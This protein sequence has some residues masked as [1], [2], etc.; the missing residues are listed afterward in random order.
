MSTKTLVA[1]IALPYAEALLEIVQKCKILE[2]TNQDLIMINQVLLES[3]QLNIFFANPLVKSSSKK[4]VIKQL[5]SGQVSDI[6]LSFL[7]VLT[8]RRRIALLKDIILKYLELE[9]VIQSI[10]IAE[11]RTA[12]QLTDQ[13]KHEL[14]KKLE[15]MTNSMKVDLNITIDTELIAGFKVTIGSKVIDTSLKGQIQQIAYFLEV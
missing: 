1:K 11:I 7:L 12:I 8:D 13:Q 4:D 14:T 3:N 5:F 2:K 9:H 15:I 6:I 10:T